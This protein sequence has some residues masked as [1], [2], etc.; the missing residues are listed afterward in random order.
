MDGFLRRICGLDS[1]EGRVAKFLTH[2]QRYRDV[3]RDILCIIR[4]LDVK[5]QQ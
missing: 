1:T 2:I 5:A 3:L 4:D